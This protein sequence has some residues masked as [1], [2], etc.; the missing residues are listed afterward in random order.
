MTFQMKKVLAPALMAAVLLVMPASAKSGNDAQVQQKLQ[1]DLSKKKQWGDVKVAV[2]DG[3]AT[4]T[5]T[6]KTYADKAKAERKAEHT[7]GVRSVVN[8][9][10]VAGGNASDSE[11]FQTIADKLRYD[12]VDQ[13]LIMGVNR[14]ITAGNTFNNFTVDVKNGV[15]TIGGNARTDADAASAVALVENTPGVK[16]VIDNIEIAPASGMDDQ[17][18]IRVARAI[19]GD[20][21]LSKYAMDPQ[22]PIRIIVEN[23]HVTLA[24]QVLNEMDKNVAGI[25]ANGVS[26]VFSV[27]NDLQA[28]NQQPR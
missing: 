22:Q 6:T 7:D 20:P 28:A 1:Q 9:V 19:Y 11:L 10:Q 13:G 3:V 26:G 21:V 17:L 5:G 18:R 24:G 27:K 16:D 2:Q 4:L 12:R 15:V 8:N 23:G 14:N 25:R